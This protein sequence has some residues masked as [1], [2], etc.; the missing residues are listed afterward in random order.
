MS[1]GALLV[2]VA[3]IISADIAPIPEL[4]TLPLAVMIVGTALS[5]IPV[6]MLMNKLG[7]KPVFLATCVVA[8]LASLTAVLALHMAS[9]WV[10]CAGSVLFG[11]AIAGFQQIRFAAMESV[12]PSKAPKAASTILLGGLFAAWLGPELSTMGAELS[13]VKFAGA[14]MLMGALCLICFVLFWFYKPTEVVSSE[15]KSGGRPLKIVITQPVILLAIGSAAI[16]YTLMSFI[17]TATPLH[18]HVMQG[19]DLEHT[20]W[21]IQ[22]HI[23]AMFLPSIITG[24]LISKI[25]IKP[26]IL[27]G[28]GCFFACLVLGYSA[29]EVP[30][31]WW[32]LILLG[33]GWN[34][35][36]LSGTALLPQGY[37]EEERFRV[38]A[39]NEFVV[40]GAQAIASL[41]AGAVL[42][43]LGW[44][45]LLIFS[46]PLL[47]ALMALLSL[48]HFSQNKKEALQ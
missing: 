1:A 18:M 19:H 12:T 24:W 10:F 46:L 23:V 15:V 44:N 3:G 40:F 21:V 17:M 37:Q 20:K 29:A 7:R 25:G 48:W 5:V 35:L 14:F 27:M 16:G 2:L 26:V 39:V 42:F 4:A 9:F 8:L 45:S 22:S 43:Q 31:F 30:Q 33:I 13:N 32:T 41:S 28:I 34:F 47:L 11:I 6:T 38:Q 36:F